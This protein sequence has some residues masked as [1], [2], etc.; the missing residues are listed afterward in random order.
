MHH[1]L[2]VA[3]PESAELLASDEVGARE[4]EGS[5]WVLLALF[6]R[7]VLVSLADSGVSRG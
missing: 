5:V 4:K 1:C 2:V 6:L 3:S 7:E